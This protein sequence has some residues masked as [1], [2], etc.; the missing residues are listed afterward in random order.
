M[1]KETSRG[2]VTLDGLD[3]LPVQAAAQ[4]EFFTGRR[5]PVKLLRSEVLKNYDV[6]NS[7]SEEKESVRARLARLESD[8][9]GFEGAV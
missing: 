6:S 9:D 5:V 2:W 1:S 7:G 3:Y 8:W 4:F